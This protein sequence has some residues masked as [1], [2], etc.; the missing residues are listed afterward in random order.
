M[1]GRGTALPEETIRT[2]APFFPG[3][4]L[5]RV[6]VREGI[7]RYVAGDPLGYADRYTIYFR[8]GEYRPDTIAGLALL[9]H[10]LAHCWQYCQCGTWRFRARYLAA[11]FKNR[12]RGLRHQEAYWNI[13]FEA[14]ARAVE[15]LVREA[16]QEPDFLWEQE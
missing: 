6:R 8:K 2:L 15:D 16:L 11:Y 4:D 7:P 1:K 13:P 3:F 10:E 9:A 12:R 14:Q 5:T